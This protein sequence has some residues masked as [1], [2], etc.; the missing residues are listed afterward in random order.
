MDIDRGASYSMSG[1]GGKVMIEA[2]CRRCGSH[3]GHILTV[4]G[5]LVH[6]ING[7]SLAFT[8]ATG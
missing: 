2:H 5:K 3:L 4:D 1:A 6:C 7:A 8:P